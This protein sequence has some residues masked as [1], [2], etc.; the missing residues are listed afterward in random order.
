MAK[1]VLITG[2]NAGIGKM[3]AQYFAQNGWR[4]VATMRSVEKAGDLAQMPN[5]HV[6]P[7]DVTQ[8]DSVEKAAAD[9]LR[10]LGQIDVVVN[11]AGF[12]V[13]GVCE[14]AT[15]AEIN[16]QFDV[17][18]KGVIRVMKAFLPHFRVRKEGLF[19]NISSVAGL[20]TYPMGSLYNAT[21]WAVEGLTEA[22]SFELRP[23]NIRVKLV[24]PGA[25][26]TNFQQVGMRWT[27]SDTIRDYDEMIQHNRE[28]RDKIQD[29]LADPIKVA[30]MIFEAANDP[31]PRL[32]YLVGDDAQQLVARRKEIGVEK[33][34]DE[35]YQKMMP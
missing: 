18:V 21:K 27:Q 14:L 35:L 25:F 7:L 26:A 13:Y 15:E 2:S 19:I 6:Y 16:L 29:Q 30:E 33:F 3:T 11:N 22:M 32:R 8:T 12:G 17:N 9:C 4:V 34:I 31:S 20:L 1:T 28:R 10:D 5:V 24:E 23:F